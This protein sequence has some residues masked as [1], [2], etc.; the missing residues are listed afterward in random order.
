MVDMIQ[1]GEQIHIPPHFSHI[2]F[3]WKLERGGVGDCLYDNL[4][5]AVIDIHKFLCRAS[6]KVC[7]YQ[8]H[9]PMVTYHHF[10]FSDRNSLQAA[11]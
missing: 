6:R 5:F 3:Q 9:G 8:C 1:N 10:Q 7:G 4:P 2:Q 11:A